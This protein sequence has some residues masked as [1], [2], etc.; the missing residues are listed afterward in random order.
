MTVQRIREIR[1]KIFPDLL[2]IMETKNPTTTV[3]NLLQGLNYP[4]HHLVEPHSPGAGG[5]ALFWKNNI[6]VEILS[7]C[8]HFIDT[9]IKAKGREFYATFLYGEPDRT[10]RTQVWTRLQDIALLRDGPWLITGDFNDIIGSNE[11]VGGLERPESFFFRP[12]LLYV[13]LRSI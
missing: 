5:L 1:K 9:R 4:S 7:S 11:K 13:H 3:L 8:P 6:E 10:K 12:A 2:F